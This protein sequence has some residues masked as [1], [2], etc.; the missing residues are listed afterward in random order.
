MQ[1]KGRT[2][3]EPL[4]EGDPLVAK[5]RSNRS[6]SADVPT[7]DSYPAEPSGEDRWEPIERTLENEAAYIRL[8]TE[9]GD[10]RWNAT[11]RRIGKAV[12]R[13]VKQIE[14]SQQSM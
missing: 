7:Y 9:R 3:S 4:R 8:Q 12:G 11:A 5:A 14:H 10:P 1:V 2:M 6:Y 13:T